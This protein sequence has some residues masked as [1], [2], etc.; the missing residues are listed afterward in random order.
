[1]NF[2]DGS[3]LRELEA[4]TSLGLSGL[5]TFFLAG[6]TGEEI[7]FAKGIAEIRIGFQES[8]GDAELNGTDLTAHATA[9][10]ADRD[11]ILIGHVGGLER[12]KDLVLERER[13]EV[14]F[15]GTLVDRDLS[16][17]GNKS[18]TGGGRLTASGG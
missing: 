1:M 4:L 2:P 3:T 6:I 14:F 7:V 10:G 9:G 18:D 5:L 12:V 13:A 11:I 16:G 8:A 15:E 17:S